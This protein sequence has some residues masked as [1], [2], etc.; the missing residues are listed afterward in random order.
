MKKERIQLLIL[1]LI[2]IAGLTYAY[3]QFLLIPEW[4]NIQTKSTYLQENQ[5]Y[6]QELKTGYEKFSL[7]KKE[8]EE[9]ESQE[10]KLNERSPQQL[11]KP[12]LMMYIYNTSKQMGL[13]P[14]NLAFEPLNEKEGYFQMGMSFS[15]RGSE[16]NIYNFLD[17]L[18]IEQSHKFSLDSIN[19]NS[20][21]DTRSVNMRLVAYAFREE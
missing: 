9:L 16:N 21:G 10:K 17:K 18:R 5:D 11:D 7:L 12:T 15:C 6:L 1:S 20:Q 13:Q 19:M 4:N 3:I 2:I 8:A 14:L